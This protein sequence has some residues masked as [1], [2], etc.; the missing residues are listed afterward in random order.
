MA[1]KKVSGMT[2]LT[3]ANVT[4]N[5]LIMSADPS[6]NDNYQTPFQDL[7]HTLAD[8]QVSGSSLFSGSNRTTLTFKT[9][10]AGSSKLTIA[11]SGT[12]LT[13]DVNESALNLGNMTGIVP[14]A[15]GGTQ[16][17]LTA[18][19]ANAI[20]FWNLG[21]G[22]MSWLQ[23]GA[24]LSIQGGNTLVAADS[25]TTYTAGTGL[26]LV[27]TTFSANFGSSAGTVTEG[28]TQYVFVAGTG[29]SGGG[30]ITSGA[31]GT[32]TYTNSDPG[33]SQL[34]FRQVSG[35]TG[36]YVAA[37]NGDYLDIVGGTG[38]STVATPN[39][40]TINSTLNIWSTISADSGSTAPVVSADTLTIAGGTGISTTIVGKTLTINNTAASG[41]EANDGIN[42]GTGAGSIYAGKSGVSLQFKSLAAGTNVN[43]TSTSDTI[44]INSPL[45]N[46]FQTITGNTGNY[47]AI[48]PGDT[49]NFVG[50]DGITA[51]VAG[52][53]VII[54]GNNADSGWLP[55]PIYSGGTGVQNIS[56]IPNPPEFRVV[57]R[58][59][60]F[61]GWLVIPLEDATNPGTLLT[62]FVQTRDPLTGAFPL[63]SGTGISLPDPGTLI[64]PPIFAAGEL[65]P[66]KTMRFNNMFGYRYTTLINGDVFP[67]QTVIDLEFEQA[68]GVNIYSVLNREKV[69]APIGAGTVM[70]F[71]QNRFL[72]NK[73]AKGDYVLDW[74]NYRTSYDSGATLQTNFTHTAGDPQFDMAFDGRDVEYFG[75]VFIPLDGLSYLV[76]PDDDVDT[77]HSAY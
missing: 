55:L 41:G 52:S 9:L 26:S 15:N 8:A 1:T 5:H 17:A 65:Y 49:L 27:G 60:F 39:T 61:R 25:D 72:I 14:L 11:D 59:V 73:V 10:L 21:A 22:S 57:N 23:I 74:A 48:S 13:L 64:M 71:G 36:T 47:T 2:P 56:N 24:N 75:G 37:I 32:I 53:S 46:N 54:T 19:A 77:I 66:D 20:M 29:L 28:D 3:I 51:D 44:T 7:F 70:P 76:D 18:P 69:A 31:G 33:S 38:I 16:T 63:T 43:I 45:Q 62:N 58:Q 68:G 40:L 30:T 42:I 12:A 35:D 4:S 67:L 34:L 6:S 50:Q